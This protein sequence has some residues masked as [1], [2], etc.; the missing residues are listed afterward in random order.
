[1]V[2]AHDEYVNNIIMCMTMVQMRTLVN[3]NNAAQNSDGKLREAKVACRE[4]IYAGMLWGGAEIPQKMES[5]L[6]SIYRPKWCLSNSFRL[7]IPLKFLPSIYQAVWSVWGYPEYTLKDLP[8]HRYSQ[9]P[10]V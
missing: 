10:R 5:I 8:P 4:G 3:Y 9:D 1:M 7:A 6:C 2:L